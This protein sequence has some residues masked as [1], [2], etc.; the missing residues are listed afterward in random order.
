MKFKVQ[1][2][3]S[4]SLGIREETKAETLQLKV[5]QSIQIKDGT[6][7]KKQI[8]VLVQDYLAASKTKGSNDEIA[9]KSLTQFKNS[10]DVLQ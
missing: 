4:S 10:S 3:K 2:Q 9:L 8:Y 7:Y 5:P 1:I 6:E